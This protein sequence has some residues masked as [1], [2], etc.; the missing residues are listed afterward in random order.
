MRGQYVNYICAFLGIMLIAIAG[1]WHFKSSA[2]AEDQLFSKVLTLHCGDK[3][4]VY[5]CLTE[6]IPITYWD[7]MGG[8]IWL[9]SLHGEEL[10]VIPHWLKDIEHQDYVENDAGEN[11]L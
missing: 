3:S 9:V 2:P 8:C 1:C 6:E 7:A 4:E 11:T 10:T 5:K